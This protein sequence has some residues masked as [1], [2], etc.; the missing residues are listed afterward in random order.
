MGHRH[1]Y[2]PLMQQGYWC[3]YGPQWPD[4]PRVPHGLRLHTHQAV[5]HCWK[6]TLLISSP[7]KLTQS[8]VCEFK[9]NQGY[10]VRFYFKETQKEKL[11]KEAKWKEEDRTTVDAVKTKTKNYNEFKISKYLYRQRLN[12]E[13]AVCIS[14]RGNTFTKYLKPSALGLGFWHWNSLWNLQNVFGLL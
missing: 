1:Q 5:L 10:L 13:S 9:V 12:G 4:D 6:D 2:R 14:C 7:R 11:E 8:D 3:R